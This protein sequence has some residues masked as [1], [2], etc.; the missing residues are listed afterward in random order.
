MTTTSRT[1]QQPF[2]IRVISIAKS[3]RRAAFTERATT[4]LEWAFQDASTSNTSGLPYDEKRVAMTYGRT[5]LR[6]EIGCFS[7]HFGLW[8]QCAESDRPLIVL[9]DDLDVDWRFLERMSARYV[10][11]KNYEYLR[12]ATTF[13]SHRVSVGRIMDREVEEL[14]GNPLGSQGYLL[15]PSQARRLVQRIRRIER[16][17]DDELDL[18]W[19]FGAPNLALSP[20]IVTDRNEPSEI[21]GETDVRKNLKL[22]LPFVLTRLS[23]KIP[24]DLYTAKRLAIHRVHNRRVTRRA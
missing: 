19:K 9:E 2:L 10:E 5:L 21:V 4:S 13:K 24:R 20:P 12:F 17:I 1:D 18:C 3:T 8:R 23:N 14:F 16:P 11:Y 22:S 7:S 15:R 6:S